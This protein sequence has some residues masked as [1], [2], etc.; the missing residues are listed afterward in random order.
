MSA[1][2]AL[3]AGLR[4]PIFSAQHQDGSDTAQMLTSAAAAQ[5]PH[6]TLHDASDTGSRASIQPHPRALECIESECTP[7]N[8]PIDAT[9]TASEAGRVASQINS[10]LVR[11]GVVPNGVKT[12]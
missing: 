4:R 9:R 10:E 8:R 12:V 5:H 11:P 2:T 7:S 1:Q 6:T 3:P